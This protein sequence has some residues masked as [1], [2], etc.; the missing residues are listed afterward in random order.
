MVNQDDAPSA[1]ENQRPTHGSAAPSPG[2]RLRVVI[3]DIAFGG[4]GVARDGDFVIFIPFVLT[5]EEV[6]IE[7]TEVKK[8]F[9]RAR[10]LSVV[11]P[12]ASRVQPQCPYFGE[13]GGCQYQHIAYEEQ[14]RLKQ[15]QIRDLF[16][17]I[18]NFPEALIQ[19]VVRCPREYGYRNR[20]MIRTQWNKRKQGLEI[21]F[22]RH[23][24][25]WV[26]DID[27]CPISEPELSEQIRRVRANPPPKGG[28][29]VVLRKYPEG[30]EVPQDSFFQNNF[31]L[32]PKLAEAVREALKGSGSRF[33]IDLYCGVGFFGIE[34]ADLVEAFIGV[35]L[36]KKAI[37][38]ARN[39]LAHRGISN[40]Q[41]IIGEA[42]QLLPG[43]LEKFPANQTTVLIDPPRTGCS[44]QSLRLLKEVQPHQLIY[45]SCHPATLARDLRILCEE[46]RF[47]LRQI[48]PFD[49]FPQTQHVECVADLRLCA[50]SGNP[51]GV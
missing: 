26:V 34:T 21:G 24:N 10:L 33:L 40:G 35:E 22:I 19:P 43:A 31:F 49:M 41:F 8:N 39:N 9:A 30:W 20:I 11:K 5:G 7:I 15:K 50:A 27:H 12:S 25:N 6:E 16:Q 51:T 32:L 2:A 42:D 1:I 17:R 44:P 18:G 37:F 47:E 46:G 28:L 38:A 13:C 3:E 4:E 36:D 29:K 48:T 14:L 45:V 23:D